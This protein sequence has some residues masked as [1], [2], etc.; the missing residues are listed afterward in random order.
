MTSARQGRFEV[1][2]ETAARAEARVK[3]V[4]DAARLPGGSEVVRRMDPDG[5][6]VYVLICDNQS[7]ELDRLLF[8]I[9]RIRGAV[10]CECNLA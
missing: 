8:D 4:L 7:I 1:R 3:A 9:E 2:I 6:G 10:V 5:G